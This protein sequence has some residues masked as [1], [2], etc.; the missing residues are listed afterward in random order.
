MLG[1]NCDHASISFFFQAP[2]FPWVHCTVIILFLFHC[3]IL[4][5]GY[6]DNLHLNLLIAVTYSQDSKM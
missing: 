4:C 5:Y 1:K 2:S 6:E 3:V